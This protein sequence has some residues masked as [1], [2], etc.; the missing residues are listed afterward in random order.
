M[1]RPILSV[2]ASCALALPVQAASAAT[3][4]A[5]PV[6]ASIQ[7]PAPFPQAE[8]AQ[9]ATQVAHRDALSRRWVLGVLEQ[10]R[11]QPAI[12]RRI[13]HPAEQAL[14][15]WQYRRI[16]LTPRRIA[17]GV[18]FWRQHRAALRRAG[19]K[20]GVDP[21]YIVAILGVETCYGRITG[22][23]RVLD[24]LSTLAFGDAPRSRLFS[25]ELAQFL[26][27]AHRD[28]LD[29][30]TVRGS[31]A[32][33]MGPMQ[34]MPSAWLGFAVSPD[35][36]RPDLFGN[37]D[38]IFASVAHY[39]QAHGWQAGAPLLAPVTVEPGATFQ[40][41]PN[42]LALDRTVGGL[43]AQGAVVTGHFA[44][45]TPVALLLAEDPAPIYRAGFNNF[46]VM[47]SY[48]GSQLYAMAVN[49]LAAAVAA[50]VERP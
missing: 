26:V 38:D 13:N 3:Q 15:W 11:A 12:L 2:L 20:W 23:Y 28:G 44:A 27:L 25:A 41:D 16:F 17:L 40:V 10:A 5:A 21:R 33:A 46:R 6:T 24:A 30:L 14:Q 7:A 1:S 48:N 8:L 47:L 36:Q 49:G 22:S 45:T 34:F 4:P 42:D 35:G 9:F 37:W 31:Y 32:G 39:L 19:T 50:Q 29:P 18:Q 43:A